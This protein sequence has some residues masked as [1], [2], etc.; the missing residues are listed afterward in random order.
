M[1][2]KRLEGNTCQIYWIS[3]KNSKGFSKK[4]KKI[5]I[6]AYRYTQTQVQF[7]FFFFFFLSSLCM[8]SAVEKLGGKCLPCIVDIRDESQVISAVEEA[9]KKFGGIDILV[10]NASAI[11]LTG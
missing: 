1:Y 6:Y 4:K 5:D 9:V 7:F 2:W 11:S 8:V 3:K 10:N